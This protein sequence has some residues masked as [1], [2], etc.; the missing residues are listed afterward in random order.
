M[1]EPCSAS[2]RGR[3]SLGV[4]RPPSLHCQRCERGTCSG[5]RLQGCSYPPPSTGEAAAIPAPAPGSRCRQQH[6]AQGRRCCLRSAA[7][8]GSEHESARPRLLLHAQLL[9]KCFFCCCCCVFSIS[10][11]VPELRASSVLRRCPGSGPSLRLGPAAP[12]WHPAA[13]HR[14]EAL[15][16]PPRAPGDTVGHHPGAVPQAE[17]TAAS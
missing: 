9:C 12:A 13:S 7:A 1:A 5:R 17:G 14:G 11:S 6:G 16:L 3:W 10:L 8:S 4:L 15:L 2:L